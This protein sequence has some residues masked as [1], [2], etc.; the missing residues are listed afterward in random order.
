MDLRGCRTDLTVVVASV[1]CFVH[2]PNKLGTSFKPTVGCFLG[3]E[4]N[5]SLGP[6]TNYH[7]DCRRSCREVL[8]AVV[9]KE[10]STAVRKQLADVLNQEALKFVGYLHGHRSLF[11]AGDGFDTASAT[12]F[13][14]LDTASAFPTVEELNIIRTSLPGIEA[15]IPIVE[16]KQR[17]IDA[18]THEKKPVENGQALEES[19]HSDIVEKTVLFSIFQKFFRMLTYAIAV[20][21][22]DYLDENSFLLL[23]NVFREMK[24]DKKWVMRRFEVLKR[25]LEQRIPPHVSKPAEEV[26]CVLSTRLQQMNIGA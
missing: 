16:D 14:K 3:K 26:I 5:R 4:K 21:S 18:L 25:E 15:V 19:D 23:E 11:H 2:C 12:L 6:S 24:V 7:H 22:T 8:R 1:G 9:S 13:R 10:S 17:I 20:L